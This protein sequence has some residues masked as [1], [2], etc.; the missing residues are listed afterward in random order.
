MAPESTPSKGGGMI[1]LYANLL[2]PSAD[3]PGTISRAPVVFKQSSD[4]DAQPDEPAAKKQQL[5]AC[6]FDTLMRPMRQW[7]LTYFH[8]SFPPLPTRQT[9]PTLNSEAKTEA[10][11]TQSHSAIS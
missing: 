9:T 10:H 2:D 3:S 8:Y 5:N 4:N 1:S 6:I 7:Q 11:T